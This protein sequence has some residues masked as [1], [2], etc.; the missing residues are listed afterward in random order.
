MLLTQLF[1]FLMLLRHLL[2]FADGTLNA[3]GGYAY[4]GSI[5]PAGTASL[6]VGFVW[7]QG[8]L[9]NGDDTFVMILD[10]AVDL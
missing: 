6:L 7:R 2:P 1:V 8:A 5:L 4:G 9:L 10:G 3:Q